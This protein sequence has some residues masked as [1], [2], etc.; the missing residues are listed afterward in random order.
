M[1]DITREASGHDNT[2]DNRM[3]PA[4]EE[5]EFNKDCPP[6]SNEEEERM[7]RPGE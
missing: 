7:F 5:A 1:I 2:Q 6:L 3:T 4:V